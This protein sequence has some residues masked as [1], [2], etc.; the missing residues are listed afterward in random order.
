MVH[1]NLGIN[2]EINI[3]IKAVGK[4]RPRWCK[5]YNYAYTPKKTKD[6][7]S[8][9]AAYAAVSMR[10][11]SEK[12]IEGP[13]SV[14]ILINDKVPKSWTDKKKIDALDGLIRPMRTPDGDNILK[15]ILDGLNK[16]A[17]LDDKQVV[18][19]YFNRLYAKEYLINI[20]I[21]R[22]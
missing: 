22:L 15:A 8:V 4:E 9:I 16:V 11:Q 20:N 10:E 13:V 2:M 18:Q 3:P 12:I 14:S 1:H 6:F 21:H 17:Y 19:F 5:R 7:E